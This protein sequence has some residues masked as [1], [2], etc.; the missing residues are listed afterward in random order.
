MAL[1]VSGFF[2]MAFDVCGFFTMAL[3]VSGFFTMAL[4][5]KAHA[6][7]FA[8]SGCKKWDTCGPEA[9]LEAEGGVLTDLMG[10]HYFYAK[11]VEH[12]NRRGVLAATKKACHGDI[13]KKMPS[14]IF[15]AMQKM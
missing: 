4:N 11:E 12:A 10:Q 3:N 15:E 8:S 13:I 7:V 5:G 1:N 2:T 14:H 6:Y 9:V